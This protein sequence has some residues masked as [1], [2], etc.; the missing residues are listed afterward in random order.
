M[1][2]MTLLALLSATLLLCGCWAPGLVPRVSGS[3]RLETK[4]MDLSDFRRVEA[5]GTFE[6]DIVQGES[7]ETAITADDNLFEY[8][9][10]SVRG[11]T[12]RL[13][14]R[15]GR[16]YT[17]TTLKARI[18]M[19][20]LRELRVSGASQARLEAFDS[21]GSLDVKASGASTLSGEVQAQELAIVLSGASRL[22]LAGNGGQL[23]LRCSG[24]SSA[25][26][27]D[28]SVGDAD[29]NLSG[30]SSATIDA[31]GRLNADLS[32]AS[33]LTYAG[34]PTLGRVSTT[35]GSSIHAR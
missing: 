14:L 25:D 32:G 20:S 21:Q 1:K 12:L 19:P 6:V 28:V 24:A 10:V 34:S 5:G 9:D 30:A 4:E 27:G 33:N 22:S 17:N 31:T 29:V 3:G 16:S 15:P 8:L 23:S 35:G 11:D 13:Q 26:L 2:R 18:V 7:F